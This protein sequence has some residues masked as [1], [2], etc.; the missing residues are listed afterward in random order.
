MFAVATGAGGAVRDAGFKRSSVNG[1]LVFLPDGGMALAAGSGNVVDIN[2]GS[3]VTRAFQ[4]VI[5]VAVQTGSGVVHA[6]IHGQTMH[7]SFICKSG[8]RQ[9][10]VAFGAA[11]FAMLGHIAEAEKWLAFDVQRIRQCVEAMPL[12][13]VIPHTSHERLDLYMENF[14][15]FRDGLLHSTGED[16]FDSPK[17]PKIID[18]LE[19]V[20]DPDTRALLGT[21]RYKEDCSLIGGVNFLNR[22][23]S[24]YR[25]G[26][27]AAMSEQNRAGTRRRLV[28]GQSFMQDLRM[29]RSAQP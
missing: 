12:D 4:R 15:L 3:R 9:A 11:A 21:I 20:F 16:L 22:I 28:I 14:T 6:P 25:D 8:A 7:R 17:F 2:S 24:K 19:T 10:N 18:F 27:A 1:F 29:A 23:A 13:G 5:A 26:R